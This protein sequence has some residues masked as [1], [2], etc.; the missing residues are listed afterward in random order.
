MPS[1][2]RR[3]AAA[4]ALALVSPRAFA[5]GGA[6]PTQPVRVIVPFS[7][8]TSDTVARL[9]G[10]EMGKALGQPVVVDNRPGAGGNLGAEQVAKS[11][12]DG[13]TLLVGSLG[14]LAVNAWLFPSLPFDP[15]AF[16]PVS[17]LIETPKVVVVNPSRPWRSLEELTAAARAAPGRLSA[18]SAGNGSSNQA[19][20][21]S[22]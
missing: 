13:H 16:A 19:M 15:R 18:G 9:V 10:T 11:E 17:L 4:A 20:P 14:P 12:P 1:V 5:Q 21:R 3:S 22:A 7:A 8:G 2:S 6:Y